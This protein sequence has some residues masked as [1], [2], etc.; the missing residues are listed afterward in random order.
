VQSCVGV[1]VVCFVVLGAGS[2]DAV[3]SCPRVKTNMETWDWSPLSG[4]TVKVM[5]KAL[6]MGRLEALPTN[7][8]G[9]S[10]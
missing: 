7:G 2:V 9:N 6:A 5:L 1:L 10:C 4:T 8:N 3:G